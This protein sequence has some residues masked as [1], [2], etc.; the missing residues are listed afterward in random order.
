[1]RWAAL[2]TDYDGTLAT[3]GIAPATTVDA[4]ERVR[5]SGRKLVLVTGRALDDLVRHVPCTTMFDMVVAENG[6][7][8]YRPA[9]GADRLLGEPPPEA[10]VDELQARGVDR[11]FVGRVVLATSRA[12]EA[13]VRDTI[14]ALGLALQVIPNLGGVMVLPE[15][16]DKATGLQ[17][18]LGDLGVSLQ[19]TI[20]IGDAENDEHLLACCGFAVA[21]ANALP[22]IKGLADWVTTRAEG[23][24]VEELVGR[25]LDRGSSAT[26]S[27]PRRTEHGEGPMNP[28]PAA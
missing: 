1:M 4:L 14:D 13:T 11:P 23:A 19:E 5:E 26:R 20:G 8:L 10:L 18:A 7:H 17:V 6:A 12:Y 3:G 16:V 2:A 22:S 21:V 25:L 24:G 15:G 27:A 9:T 28:E